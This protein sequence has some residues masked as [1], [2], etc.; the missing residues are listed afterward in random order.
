MRIVIYKILIFF[1]KFFDFFTLKKIKYNNHVS[2]KLNLGCGLVV[3]KNYINVDLSPH[4]FLA[5]FPDFIKIR[6]FSISGA[7]KYY[8]VEEYLNIINNHKF[9]YYDLTKSIPAE[10]MSIDAIYTSHF[11]EH[12]EYESA[13][14]F[15][16]ECFRTLRNNGIIRI[17]IPDLDIA[18]NQLNTGDNYAV[19]KKFFF[20][21]ENNNDFSRHKF[22]YNFTSLRKLLEDCGFAQVSKCKFMEGKL[23]EAKYLD[24]REDESLF[25]EAIK[26]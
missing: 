11:L 8:S 1:F 23:K 13:K 20:T 15:I 14:K 24:N 22:M 16:K 21:Y 2:N 7:S 10:N 4:A 18:K 19:L 5:N 26:K 17:S 3:H 6:F 12:I 9:L 25:V